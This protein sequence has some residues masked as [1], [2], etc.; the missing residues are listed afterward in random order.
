MDETLRQAFW[1]VY[2]MVYADYLVH[3]S[4]QS[5]AAYRSMWQV[6]CLASRPVIHEMAAFIEQELR[7][8]LI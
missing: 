5:A 4:R 3:P 6:V 2:R 1:D 7:D 8:R